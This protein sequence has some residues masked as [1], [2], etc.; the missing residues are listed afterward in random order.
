HGEDEPR[1]REPRGRPDR[2]AEVGPDRDARE[3]KD[4]EPGPEPRDDPL[5]PLALQDRPDRDRPRDAPH[6]D[7][8]DR[9]R[10]TCVPVLLTED[11]D[12]DPVAQ[13]PARRPADP[14]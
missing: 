7:E 6:R 2:P 14:R 9:E 10:R 12:D 4:G 5:P 8:R 3:E 13:Q 1:E 11:E